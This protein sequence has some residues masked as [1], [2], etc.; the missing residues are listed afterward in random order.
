MTGSTQRAHGVGSADPDATPVRIIEAARARLLADGYAALSTR[1]VADQAGVPLS[2]I[3]Y[4]F[5]G[6][7]GLLLAMLD[8]E[9]RRLG[10]RRRELDATAM[11]LSERC[12]QACNLLDNDLD[13]GSVRVLHEML[14]AGWSDE[15]IAE[16]VLARLDGWRGLLV[17]V[18]GEQDE[19]L[20]HLVGLALLGGEAL[21]LLGDDR[22]GARVRSALRGI[23]NLLRTLEG[24]R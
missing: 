21:L 8:H 14:A 24:T 10:E 6:R 20:A 19:G 2:Q 4:H 16:Q 23:G 5:G 22:S 18:V 12:D 15:A 7:R 17:G 9:D 11:P 1:K 13:S 3:H